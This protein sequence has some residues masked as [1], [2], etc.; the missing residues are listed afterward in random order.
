MLAAF[1]S[2]TKT[3]GVGKTWGSPTTSWLRLQHLKMVSLAEAL[4][5]SQLNLVCMVLPRST[6]GKRLYEIYK[7]TV[8]S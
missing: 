8:L 7:E 6:F 5:T 4:K 2:T 3:A 1:K